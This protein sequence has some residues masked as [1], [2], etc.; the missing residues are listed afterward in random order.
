MTPH[1]HPLTGS[2]DA[3]TCQKCIMP[4]CSIMLKV[5]T[6]TGLCQYHLH[7][8]GLCTCKG[9]KRLSEQDD[10]ELSGYPKTVTN[11]KY[12]R[13]FPEKR[14]AHKL[15]ERAKARGEI[16]QQDCETCGNH[17][18]QAH[19]DDYS[20]PLDIRWLCYPCHAEVHRLLDAKAA[21]VNL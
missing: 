10:G 1:S 5:G 4:D 15:V 19:H 3:V 16:S 13:K 2:T 14:R 21:E 20:R 12:A 8:Q 9:C 6:A 18:S 17:K 11:R 7:T